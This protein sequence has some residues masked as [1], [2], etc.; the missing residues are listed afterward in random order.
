MPPNSDHKGDPTPSISGSGYRAKDKDKSKSSRNQNQ[1]KKLD[2]MD[3]LGQNGKL[4]QQEHQWHLDNEL[5]CK[6]L[7]HGCNGPQFMNPRT[8]RASESRSSETKAFE[9]KKSHNSQTSACSEHCVDS[10][11]ADKEVRLNASALSSMS[12]LVISLCSDFIPH[13]PL[14][15]TSRFQFYAL[16]HRIHFYS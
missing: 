16:F 14:K 5:C 12:S 13:I 3:N 8:A 2:L 15:S 9:P 1:Q 6:G 10:L 4:T 11:H 7:S